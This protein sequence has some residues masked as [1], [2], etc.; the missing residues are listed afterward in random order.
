MQASKHTIK[1]GVPNAVKPLTEDEKKA[2]LAR[3]LAQKHE[4]LFQGILFNAV[5]AGTFGKDLTAAVDAAEAA[6]DHAMEIVF[7]ARRTEEQ[8]EGQE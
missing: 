5:Q 6:A 3:M 8:K 4:T 7:G 2:T 1:A